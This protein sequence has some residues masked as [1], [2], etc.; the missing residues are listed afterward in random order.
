[1]WPPGRC[2][3]LP[4][5]LGR[6]GRSAR[7]TY[8]T[9]TVSATRAEQKLSYSDAPGPGPPSVS[10]RVYGTQGPVIPTVLRPPR[11]RPRPGARRAG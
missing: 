3:R 7:F 11:T 8:H 10:R 9:R 4:Y 6:R 1:M 5:A 2:P